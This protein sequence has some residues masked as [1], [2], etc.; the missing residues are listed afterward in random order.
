[1]QLTLQASHERRSR[2]INRH[3]GAWV[4]QV[5]GPG[6]HSYCPG[7]AWTPQI[8]LYESCTH[9]CVVVDLAGVDASK[10]DIRVEDRVLVLAG[11]RPS[12]NF[13]EPVGDVQLHHM[14]IDHGRFCRSLELPADVD[15]ETVEAFYRGGMLWIHLPKKN[16]G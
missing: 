10:I 16:Q 2:N 4:D 9:Y 15:A 8:N 11:F 5:L 13:P 3:M 12:P 14:E 6:F 7:D 1:M